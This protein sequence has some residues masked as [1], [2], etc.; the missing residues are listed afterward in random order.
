MGLAFVNSALWNKDEV[1][2]L[3]KCMWALCVSEHLKEH[4]AIVVERVL[5][6]EGF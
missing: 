6:K 5:A 4:S 2:Q 1:L 3:K